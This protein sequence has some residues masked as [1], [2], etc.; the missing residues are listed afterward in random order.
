MLSDEALEPSKTTTEPARETSSTS[1]SQ[2][3][4]GPTSKQQSNTSPSTKQ[5]IANWAQI[6]QSDVGSPKASPPAD[7]AATRQKTERKKAKPATPD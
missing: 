6:P 4:A 2:Q 3:A 5:V 1:N 7:I